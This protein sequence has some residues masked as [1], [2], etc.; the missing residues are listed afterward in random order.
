MNTR[1]DGKVALVTGAAG[2]IGSAVA[3]ALAAEGARTVLFDRTPAEITAESILDAGGAA[4]TITGDV[5]LDADARRGVETCIGDYSG[6][7]IL[8]N[9]AGVV[10]YA[11]VPDLSEEDWDLQLDTNL[12]GAFLLSKHAVPAMRVRGAGAIVTVASAQALASQPL[13]AAYSA[14]KAGIV[15][16]TK[17]MAIDHG[18]DNIRVNCVLPGS[19]LTDM[20]RDSARQFGG[21]D[22]EGALDEWGTIHPIGRLIRP[23]EIAAAILFLVSDQ[24]SAITGAPYL[25]DGGLTARLAV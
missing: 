8:V 2:G 9:T 19:V 5:R 3:R 10:R 17:T 20:L 7:D 21:D 13:V 15:A 14:A 6:L 24:S 11:E 12:K 23:E 16:L 25:I 1:L 4:V 18:K 22:P